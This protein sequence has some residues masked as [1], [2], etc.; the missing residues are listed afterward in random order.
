MGKALTA[1]AK[2]EDVLVIG[3]GLITHN[4]RDWRAFKKREVWIYF[5][6]CRHQPA[7]VLTCASARVQQWAVDFDKWVEEGV[8]KTGKEREDHFA[9]FKQHPLI[10]DAHPRVEHFV[11]L[12]PLVGVSG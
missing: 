5:V 9:T 11:P 1:L 6:E 8:T 10:H 12:L 4:L 3:S 2:E 7:A